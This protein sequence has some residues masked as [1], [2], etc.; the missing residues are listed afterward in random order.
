MVRSRRRLIASLTWPGRVWG[1][2]S[3]KKPVYQSVFGFSIEARLLQNYCS[4]TPTAHPRDERERGYY[5]TRW[6][7]KTISERVKSPVAKASELPLSN[8]S[9]VTF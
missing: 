6:L 2:D 3:F 8:G 5:M 7:S 4:A 1:W 9:S